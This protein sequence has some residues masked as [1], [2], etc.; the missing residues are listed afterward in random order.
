[1]PQLTWGGQARTAASSIGL[2]RVESGDHEVQLAKDRRFHNLEFS[3]SL[4][5]QGARAK[6]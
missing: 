2:L 5:S 3:I 6:M 1:M 4:P